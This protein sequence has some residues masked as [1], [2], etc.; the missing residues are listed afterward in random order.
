MSFCESHAPIP[1]GALGQGEIQ[2]AGD[3]VEIR[4]PID[5]IIKHSNTKNAAVFTEGSVII[6]YDDTD[7]STR[8]RKLQNQLSYLLSEKYRHSVIL[9]FLSD[10]TIDVAIK[11]IEP[12]HLSSSQ[13]SSS[14]IL[15]DIEANYTLYS[16]E[17]QMM[18]RQQLTTLLS[19]TLANMIS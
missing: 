18:L 16:N 17:K 5:G 12:D 2:L 8:E 19:H 3:K 14:S 4:S 9:Q 15:R 13:A 7:I 11:D 10:I 6:E 1:V